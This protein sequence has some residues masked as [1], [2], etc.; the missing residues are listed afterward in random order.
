[1]SLLESAPPISSSLMAMFFVLCGVGALFGVALIAGR[2]YAASG[3]FMILVS[4]VLLGLLL[5]RVGI[6]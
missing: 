2:R 5:H 4:L 3:V 6:L 1:M